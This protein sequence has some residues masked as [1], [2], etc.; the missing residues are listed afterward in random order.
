MK[1]GLKVLICL[2]A[3]I[4]IGV[5]GFA[6]YQ[7]QEKEKMIKIATSE[8]ARKVYEDY[9]TTLDEKALTSQGKIRKYK[10][11]ENDLEYNPIGGA[12]GYSIYKWRKRNLY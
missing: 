7:H 8:E 5:G 9:L 6:V 1:K 2:L 12:N 11:D 10:V 4:G 3:I